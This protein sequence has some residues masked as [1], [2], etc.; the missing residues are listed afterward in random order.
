MNM[1][2]HLFSLFILRRKIHLLGN[3]DLSILLWEQLLVSLLT[4]VPSF[5]FY[6]SCIIATLRSVNA[7]TLSVLPSPFPSQLYSLMV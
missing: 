4:A 6:L 1:C 5:F 2:K 3:E 7:K